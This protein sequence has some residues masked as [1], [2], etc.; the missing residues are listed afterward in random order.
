MLRLFFILS[1][2]LPSI[3][4]AGDVQ[5]FYSL[6]KTLLESKNNEKRIEAAQRLANEYPLKESLNILEAAL[7]I[8]LN[9]IHEGKKPGFSKVIAY[10]EAVKAIATS[11]NRELVERLIQK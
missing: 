10:N 8:E 9:K 5:D 4:Y 2:I 3:L 11:G 6:R 7:E 1:F